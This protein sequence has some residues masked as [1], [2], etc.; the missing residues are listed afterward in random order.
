M[1]F[2]RETIHEPEAGKN[3]LHL[4][5]RALEAQPFQRARF[6]Q[7]GYGILND[8]FWIWRTASKGFWAFVFTLSG[9]GTIIMEDGTKINVEKG[10]LFI[11]SPTGQGHYEE[12][13]DG[14]NWE[15]IWVTVW[16]DSPTFSPPVEDYI[17]KK[18]SNADVLRD[19]ILGVIRE[20][21]YNDGRSDDALFYYE[22]LFLIHLSRAIGME[23]DKL[24]FRHRQ[25]LS[26]LWAQVSGSI[27][28]TWD[29]EALSRES[30]YSK[31]HLTRICQELYGKTPGKMVDEIRMKQAKVL[32]LNSVQ[33]ID[34][35][36]SYLGYSTLSSFSYAFKEYYGVSPREYRR[37][38]SNLLTSRSQ[39]NIVS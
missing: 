35:I 20:E 10:D 36:S 23:E 19:T 1:V 32:L 24:A 14:D 31:S 26:L 29:L 4:S 34:S 39:S 7:G 13:P 11:S 22:E 6:K 12:T 21:N 27:S 18:F 2:T 8:D 30:G 16:E 15:M 3:N 17:M 28:S 9:K 5:S 38:N 25:E 33:S 37:K